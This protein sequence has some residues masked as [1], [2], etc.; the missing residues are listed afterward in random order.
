MATDVTKLVS[1]PWTQKP[2]KRTE[3]PATFLEARDR[4]GNI[5]LDQ[6]KYSEA[7]EDIYLELVAEKERTLGSNHYSTLDTIKWLGILYSHLKR[8]GEAEEM[9]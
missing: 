6:G 7:A 8:V 4:L 3:R 5:F 2:P 1:I 9:I